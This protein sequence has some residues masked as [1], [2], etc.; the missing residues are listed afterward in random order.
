MNSGRRRDVSDTPHEVL[1]RCRDRH[2][3]VCGTGALN[4]LRQVLQSAHDRYTANH[5]GLQGRVIVKHGN[6]TESA[7]GVDLHSTDHSLAQHAGAIDER[8]R[9][10]FSRPKSA[11]QIRAKH[12]TCT[13]D[14]HRGP[15]HVPERAH[16]EKEQ[17][18]DHRH[19]GDGQSHRPHF[20]ERAES[21]SASVHPDEVAHNE[22]DGSSDHCDP[23]QWPP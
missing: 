7:V 12:I 14:Q 13:Q 20:I 6:W 10:A 18:H 15:R 9:G 17:G 11:L 19:D 23:D 5:S 1:I 2:D 4:D 3:Q 21:V 16:D 8:R 22:M